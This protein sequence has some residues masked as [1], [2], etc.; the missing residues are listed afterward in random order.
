VIAVSEDL[1]SLGLKP[2]TEVRIEGLRRRY[3]VADRTHSR[4]QRTID[5]YVP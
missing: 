1:L 5:I 3:R 4:L 2:G